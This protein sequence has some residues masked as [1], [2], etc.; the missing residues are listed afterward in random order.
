MRMTRRM[1]VI[2]VLELNQSHDTSPLGKMKTVL[3]VDG[4]TP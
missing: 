1:V 3:L 4:N 2:E